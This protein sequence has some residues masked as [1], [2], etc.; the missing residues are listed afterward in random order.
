[1]PAGVFAAEYDEGV[2]GTGDPIGIALAIPNGPTV[3][4]GER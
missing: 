3:R 4:G 2:S 1:M